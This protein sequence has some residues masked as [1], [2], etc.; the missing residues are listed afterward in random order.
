MECGEWEREYMC[1]CVCVCLCERQRERGSVCLCVCVCVCVCVRARVRKR[2]KRRE[3]ERERKRERERRGRLEWTNLIRRTLRNN[4]NENRRRKRKTSV[5]VFF[6]RIAYQERGTL[7]ATTKNI[8]R[9][10]S[11]GSLRHSRSAS[12]FAYKALGK[13]SLPDGW[14]INVRETCN[15]SFPC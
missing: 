7:K 1:V 15:F 5:V 11:P 6:S 3:R 9:R 13:G 8:N 12:T 10:S 14:L 4:E 2:E